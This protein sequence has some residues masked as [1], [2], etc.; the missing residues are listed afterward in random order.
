MSLPSPGTQVL[1]DRSKRYSSL[2]L[3]SLMKMFRRLVRFARYP[4]REK[5]E[6]TRSYLRIARFR[7]QDWGWRVPRLGNDR[8]T[9]VIGL[10]GGR[11]Y[12]QRQLVDNIGVRNKYISEAIRLHPGPTSMI[13]CGHATLR[14]VSRFQEAPEVTRRIFEAV[15]ARIADVIFINRHPLDSLMTNWVWWRTYL[16]SKVMHDGISSAY[17]STGNF[18]VELEQNFQEF[19]AFAEGD[20][21]FFGD[22]P[23]PPFLSFRE[24]VEEIELYRESP[25]REIRL[26][27]CSADPLKEFR[28]VLQVMSVDLDLRR[29]RVVP[30]MPKP[31]RYL[32]VRE[33]VPRFRDFIEGLDAETKR[34]IER[35][36]YNLAG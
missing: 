4:Y 27:D 22:S 16:R 28:K 14:H 18:C 33:N 5:R 23:G 8:T 6:I 17:K 21:G 24:F 25:A 10:F 13:Y 30:P 32:E 36:G 11:A 2:G 9:Y 7:L 3:G 26:E 35:A 31:Y 15:R 12:I 1:T 19:K 20:P 29:V 34:R